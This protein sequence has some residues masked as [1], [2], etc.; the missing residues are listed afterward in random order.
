M[1]TPAEN[2]KTLLDLADDFGTAMLVTHDHAGGLEARPMS[3]V[4]LTDDGVMWFVTD[5]RSGKVDQIAADARVLVTMQSKTKQVELVGT[6]EVVDDDATLKAKWSEALD[7]WFP[8][9]PDSDAA[10]L[11]RVDATTGR[12]W[13][14]SG[15]AG[16]RFAWAA[17]KA[18][19]KGEAIDPDE[20]GD[21][22]AARVG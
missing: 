7:L 10:V 8:D 2:R 19:V 22:G 20:A 9:G 18:A 17:T 11:L 6:A 1:S 15:L 5:V 12:Y 3:V 16:L 4:E 14:A 13:D 21:H